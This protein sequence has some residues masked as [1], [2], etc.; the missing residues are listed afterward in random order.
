MELDAMAFAAHGDDIELSCGGTLIKLARL[1]YKIGA[2]ELT[3]GELSTR[4][5]TEEREE[6]SRRAAELLGLKV[7]ENLGIPDGNIESSMENKLKVINIIRL[8]RPRF[9]FTSYWHDRHFD[10][11][12]SSQ[13]VSEACFYSGLQKID[14]GTKP[15]RPRII[16]YFQ[17]RDEFEPTFLVDVSKEFEQKM[18]AIRA[19]NSQFFTPE[20]KEPESFISS[21]QFMEGLVN[22]LRYYGARIGVEYAEPFLVKESLRIDDPLAF[23]SDF[24]PNLIMSTPP[25]K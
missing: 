3:R 21:S 1:G 22:R 19:H 24:D 18:A 9:I 11:V 5:D 17:H 12:H 10:H 16:I 14:T 7:R 4:G 8:Y 2:C 20:S 6:E 25:R 13:L 15:F 23:F